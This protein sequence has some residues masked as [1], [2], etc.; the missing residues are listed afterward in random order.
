MKETAVREYDGKLITWEYRSMPELVTNYKRIHKKE[1][2]N[3]FFWVII[4]VQE[5]KK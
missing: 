1:Y 5:N 4:D 3:P 2:C